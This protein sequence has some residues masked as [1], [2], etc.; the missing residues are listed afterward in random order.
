MKQL[1]AALSVAALAACTTSNPDVISRY[2][3]QR[4]AQVQDATVLSVRPVVVDG[5][6]SGVG[7]AAGAVAGGVAG[8]SIG[9]SREGVIFGVL[10][11]VAGGLAG[12]AVE[13]NGTK[14]N[15]LE[16]VVQL[17]NGERRSIVQ[18]RDAT[19]SSLVPGAAVE[20]VTSNGRTRVRPV[21]ANPPPPQSG[22]VPSA[23]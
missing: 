15:A 18:G 5:S 2:D 10:G 3:T 13:R 12:N 17:R 22:P 9:G 8:S 20:L 1:I 19:E 16:V 11:A 23:G 14:E 6:Q 7:A 21:Y 4:M